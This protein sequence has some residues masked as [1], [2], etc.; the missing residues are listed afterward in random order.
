MSTI[1]VQQHSFHQSRKRKEN[2]E[3]YCVDNL[4]G[5]DLLDFATTNLTTNT[6]LPVP[7]KNRSFNVQSVKRHQ[8][9]SLLISTL[10][11]PSGLTGAIFDENG[12]IARKILPSDSTTHV[13]RT[14]II[15]PSNSLY[16]YSFL[17]RHPGNTPGLDVLSSLQSQ[18]RLAQTSITWVNEWCQFGDEFLESIELKGIE[19]RKKN[20][21]VSFGDQIIP[22]GKMIRSITPPH[23]KV[24]PQSWAKQ[25]VKHQISAQELL[26]WQT[27]ENDEQVL[28]LK[29]PNGVTKRYVVERGD[30]P[31][32]QV[33][34]EDNLPDEAFITEC[35]K[36]FS[37][38]GGTN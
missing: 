33:K 17:E 14:F 6:T 31:K 8:D 5:Y 34:V 4:N 10:A 38:I 35:Q 28:D 2:R 25:I 9:R 18:W 37:Q 29:G 11:G 30:L 24:L 16:A 15:A 13:G 22:V 36:L 27:D 12:E 19:V 20:Q 23:G 21:S 1:I 26:L 32:L 7:N 3:N